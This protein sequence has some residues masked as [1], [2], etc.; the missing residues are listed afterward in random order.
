MGQ[1]V[2]H[3]R[4]YVAAYVRFVHYAERLHTVA[5]SEAGVLEPHHR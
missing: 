1:S 2:A 3:G 4:E 5:A